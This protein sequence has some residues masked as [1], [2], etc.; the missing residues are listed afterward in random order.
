MTFRCLYLSPTLT[1]AAVIDEPRLAGTSERHRLHIDPPRLRPAGDVRGEFDRDA[2]LQG[3]VLEMWLGWPSFRQLRLASRLI[4]RGRRIWMY[5]PTEDAVECVD[6]ERVGRGWRLWLVASVYMAISR[7]ATR[8]AN[9]ARA[10]RSLA[11]RMLGGKLPGE[12]RITVRCRSL[13]AA[14]RD[15][16]APVPFRQPLPPDGGSKIA[17]TGLYL[18]LDFWA[19]ISSGG[20]YGHTCYVAKELAAVT[21][22]MQCFMA[23]PYTLLDELGIP[24]RVLPPPADAAGENVIVEASRHYFLRLRHE[25]TA[26]SAP[27]AYIYERLVLGNFAGPMLSQELGIPY[28]VEYNGSELSMRRSFD[29]S[30]YIHEDVY[31]RAEALAFEQAT[32]ISVVSSEI[33]SSLVAR[34]VPA[35]K[36]LVNP[37]GADLD[38][39]APASPE[40]KHTLRSEL[41]L[42][43]ADRVVGFSGTFGGWH[44]VDVLAAGIPRICD[45]A[46]SARFLL[47]GDGSYKHLVDE[48]VAAHRLEDRVVRVGRVPQAAGA[49]LLKAC[50]IYVSPHSSHMVDSRFFGSPTKLFEYMAMSGGVVA[51]EL[52]QIGEVM[53]P[54]LRPAQLTGPDVAVTDERGV[55]CVPGSVDEFVAAV[56]G[57]VKAPALCEALGRNARQAVVDHFSWRRHVARLWDFARERPASPRAPAGRRAG[58]IGRRRL[59]RL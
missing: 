54:S 55:L 18:R 9:A 10:P 35:G 52:E 56:V 27:P 11:R 59:A 5:W 53:S 2:T 34:G 31:L 36:I 21:E 19:R 32:M 16:V 4:A 33:K 25:I 50:D 40:D 49:R 47:I 57:L 30:R 24:Q 1:D 15:R 44:G 7:P 46:P 48:A 20:S 42:R 6:R 51:S 13:I 43:D 22:R 14:L 41:G 17:G 28:I 37:N 39:Y 58:L 3:A 29:H 38:A 12:W 8:F 26:L 45:A 23:A